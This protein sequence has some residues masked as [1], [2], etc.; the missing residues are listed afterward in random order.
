MKKRIVEIAEE[1]ETVVKG[2]QDYGN[3][4]IPL[5]QVQ[6]AQEEI[7]RILNLYFNECRE[8]SQPEDFAFVYAAYGSLYIKMGMYIPLGIDGFEKASGVWF[9]GPEE[10]TEYFKCLWRGISRQDYSYFARALELRPQSAAAAMYLFAQAASRFCTVILQGQDTD[11]IE[12]EA[13]KYYDLLPQEYQE[14]V[15]GEGNFHRE[16][17][18]Q[19]DDPNLL[20]YIEFMSMQEAFSA[21]LAFPG[22]NAAALYRNT[23]LHIPVI[24]PVKTSREFF[25]SRRRI[26][27]QKQELER[28]RRRCQDMMDFYMHS[29]KH[30]SYPQTVKSVAGELRN[31]DMTLSSKL[32]KAY[33]SE[34]TLIGN[35]Q[36]IQYSFDPRPDA[37]SRAF[38]QGFY[39]AGAASGRSVPD[40]LKES[41]DLVLFKILMEDADSSRR[42]H[43]CRRSLGQ[44]ISLEHLRQSYV[45]AFID[46]TDS[47]EDICGW[48]DRNIF[49]MEVSVDP[50]WQEV[51]V[52]ENTFA[53]SQ[54]TEIFAE[55]FT[56]LLTHGWDWCRVA[57]MS[58]E[59]DLYLFVSNG[60]G[61]EL[62][63]SQKGLKGLENIVN[64]LN[65][66]QV[67]N[68]VTGEIKDS[69][70][71]EVKVV[72]RRGLLYKRGRRR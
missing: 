61:K 11:E 40:L 30:I 60:M 17:G 44:H 46:N 1:I 49:R 56:N 31:Q 50:V 48:F 32:F 42:M 8:K 27:M 65:M 53:E 38:S 16:T 29:W 15:L 22:Q 37:V 47:P 14:Y 21:Q 36:R 67:Q 24:L 5:P 59:Q 9:E 57:L 55:L 58:D 68:A 7:I 64:E 25:L 13:W 6:A 41:L 54:L 69:G 35:L 33:N 28:Q 20:P 2:V 10:Q 62:H 45:A 4:L 18:K 52:M 23:F 43:L 66:G 39:C 70:A 3:P 72:L 19:A 34:R 26:F 71:Y 63:G 51:P 12:T